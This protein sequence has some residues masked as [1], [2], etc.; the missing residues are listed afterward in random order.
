MLQSADQH[1][2]DEHGAGSQPDLAYQRGAARLE[3]RACP[4]RRISHRLF[5]YLPL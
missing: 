3:V 4:R 2:E 5:T 1:E